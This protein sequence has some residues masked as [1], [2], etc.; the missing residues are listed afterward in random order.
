MRGI[1]LL[2]GLLRSGDVRGGGGLSI[3]QRGPVTGGNGHL[4]VLDAIVSKIIADQ[5]RSR[6]LPAQRIGGGLNRPFD[7]RPQEGHDIVPPIAIRVHPAVFDL[8][9]EEAVDHGVRAGGA[10]PLL[11]HLRKRAGN[12]DLAALRRQLQRKIHQCLDRDVEGQDRGGQARDSPCGRGLLAGEWLPRPVAVRSRSRRSRRD[13]AAG[14]ACR[15]RKLD[16]PTGASAPGP[17]DR[18]APSGDQQATRA[19][20]PVAGAWP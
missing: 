12:S 2:I 5:R 7:R 9:G 20:W 3:W 14:K 13:R 1:E 4:G 19:W 8:L 11:R 15:L 16:P 6:E 18:R 17:P 10:Q